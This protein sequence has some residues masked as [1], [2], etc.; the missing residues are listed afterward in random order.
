MTSPWIA[1]SVASAKYPVYTRGNAG[2]VMPDPV[3]PLS[4][5]IGITGPGEQGWRDAYVRAGAMDADEF[6]LDRP[7]TCAVF[8]GYLY[9]NLSLIRIYGVRMP[10]LTPEIADKQY[11]GDLPGVLAYADE[12]RPTDES[13]KHMALMAQ[14]LGE[15]LARDDFPEARADRDEVARWVARRPDLSAMSDQELVDFARSFA[16]LYRRLFC[17]HILMSGASGVGIGTVAQIL[18]EIGRP[19]LL[20]TVMAGLGDVD[21][22]APSFA[23][24][25]LGRLVRGS[26]SLTALFDAGISGLEARLADAAAAGDNDA[27]EFEWRFGHFLRDYGCR[28]PNEWEFRSLV[29]GTKP[30]LPLAAIERMRLAADADS[31]TARTDVRAAERA[32]AT[33]EVQ[34]VLAG[35]AEAA[36]MFDAGLRLAHITNIGRER[37]KT[38]NI[39]IVHEMRLA[40]RELGR[41][42]VARGALDTVEQLFMLVDSELDLFVA[43]PAA[44]TAVVRE[45]EAYYTSLW[46]LEPPFVSVGA[47]PPTSQ[48]PRRSRPGD[49]SVATSVVGA[50]LSGIAGCPGKAVG[51]ARVVLD[52]ADPRGLEPGEVLIAPF[53]DPSWTPLFVPAAAV[54]VDV[55]AQITHAVIVSRELGLPCVVSVTGATRSIPD[56]A[57]VEVDGSAGTVTVLELP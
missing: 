46:D 20:M 32:A 4:A 6:E 48:W 40:F 47:P 43:D 33:A 52:P 31:P 9:L 2:E 56:G 45:R 8:G 14:Y 13:P 26:A 18:A 16:P 54:V 39:R 51:R 38:N 42:M 19:E 28:G 25:E 17:Q 23:L 37:T 15:L 12:A 24:W 30:E 22:A 35:N 21:S 44:Y 29:W 36:L 5:S 53:T 11:L 10:G 41:R 50:V 55:G 1:D 57:L 27:A 7:N 49:G 3:S 34:A